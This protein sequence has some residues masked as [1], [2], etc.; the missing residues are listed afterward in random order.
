MAKWRMDYANKST[1]VKKATI[2]ISKI[3]L[4]LIFFMDIKANCQLSFLQRHPWKAQKSYLFITKYIDKW[5]FS[6]W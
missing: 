5:I 6:S 3:K 2:S 4:L 1:G